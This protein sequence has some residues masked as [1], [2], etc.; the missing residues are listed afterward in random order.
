MGRRVLPVLVCVAAFYAVFVSIRLEQHDARW[1]V[2]I[3][4]QFLVG[5]AHEPTSS[6]L[7]RRQNALVYDGQYY[8]A[9]AAD[10]AH[11][12]DYMDGQA[13]IVYSRVLYPAVARAASGGSVAALPYALLVV[14]LLG[15]ARRQ[16][17]R[18]RCGSSSA[19]S[20]RGRRSSTASSRGSS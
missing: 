16:R 18:W 17:P 3:G 20:R 4:S 7:A 12:H 5:C 10:P 15:S 11:A 14:N 6:V 2:H 1:F 9:L 8:F 19:A 13:G